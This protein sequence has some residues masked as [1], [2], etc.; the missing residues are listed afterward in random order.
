MNLRE[1]FWLLT[2]V[3][4]LKILDFFIKLLWNYS[5][6]VQLQC[7]RSFSEKYLVVKNFSFTE[8]FKKS[9][10]AKIVSF[11]KSSKKLFYKNCLILKKL[12]CKKFFIHKKLYT[13]SF[14]KKKFHSQK[15]LL[16][17]VFHFFHIFIYFDTM[18]YIIEQHPN[19]ID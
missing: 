13:C 6:M 15:A 5:R 16:Q 14:A 10:F 7:K 19:L 12:F 1:F 11:P 9:S 3:L 17:K 18:I 8:S 4:A 2:N